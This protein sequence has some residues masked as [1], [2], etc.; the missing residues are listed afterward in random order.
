MKV[1][2]LLSLVVMY[3]PLTELQET[4]TKPGQDRLLF[5]PVV[6]PDYGLHL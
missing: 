3:R 1:L 2:S 6:L 4:L 5:A